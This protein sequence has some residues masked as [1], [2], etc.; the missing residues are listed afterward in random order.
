MRISL[1]FGRDAWSFWYFEL[2]DLNDPIDLLNGLKME[3]TFHEKT[4]SNPP[5]IFLK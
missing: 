3:F 5:K 4:G 2:P 1:E